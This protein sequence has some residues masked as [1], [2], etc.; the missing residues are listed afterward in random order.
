MGYREAESPARMA[1]KAW[2]MG[3][4]ASSGSFSFTSPEFC[5]IIGPTQ[6]LPQDAALRAQLEALS[7]EELQRRC[8]QSGLLPTGDGAHSVQRLLALDCF[9]RAARGEVVASRPEV[10]VPQLAPADPKAAERGGWT[11]LAAPGVEERGCK[12]SR[13]PSPV[14]VQ[15][16]NKTR[17]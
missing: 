9:R 7:P 11:Q 2:R 13:S 15:A 5:S 10:L 17:R 14:A 6:R 4:D 8:R 1:R 16:G 3:S 12:R